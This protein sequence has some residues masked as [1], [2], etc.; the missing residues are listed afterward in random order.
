M[1]LQQQQ[2]PPEA[3]E[4]VAR[5]VVAARDRDQLGVAEPLLAAAVAAL[6]ERL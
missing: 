5:V 2:Q 1:E 4:L 6:D 3:L